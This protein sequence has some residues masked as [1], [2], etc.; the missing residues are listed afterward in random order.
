LIDV[1][2][3][4]GKKQGVAIYELVAE[5]GHLDG[6]AKAFLDLFNDG[7]VCY[8]ERRWSEAIAVFQ[9]TGRLDPADKPSQILLERCRDYAAHPP[10]AGWSGVIEL[11]QK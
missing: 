5:K 9:E 3:V 2:A 6:E 4:K 1:V 11:T 8:R 7:M 10:A